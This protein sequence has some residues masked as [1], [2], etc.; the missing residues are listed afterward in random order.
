MGFVANGNNT[1]SQIEIK[2]DP[3][4]PSV[5]LDR[6]REIVRI[7]GAVTNERLKQ[8]IIEEVIDINRLLIRLK[9]QVSKLSDLSKLQVNDLP[10][11]D[12][13][14]LSAIANGVAAKVNENY[15]NYDSSDSGVKK[16]KEAECTVDDYRRNKQWA[17]QQ[18][19]GEN[20]TVVELI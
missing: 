11:T 7:D 13:L 19:L 14:Y 9:D 10:E 17:I 1:P 12:F 5:A 6:I 16:A 8:T 4:Y 18:L 20:H 2:S 3:F 15:R